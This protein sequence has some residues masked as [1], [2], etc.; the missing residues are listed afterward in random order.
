MKDVNWFRRPAAVSASFRSF[1]ASAR[2]AYPETA[3]ALPNASA[4]SAYR[5]ESIRLLPSSKA[6]LNS[7]WRRR[8]SLAV[9]N[10]RAVFP[11]SSYPGTSRASR[12]ASTAPAGSS[13]A[14]LVCAAATR[15]RCS[16]QWRY[17]SDAAGRGNRQRRKHGQHGQPPQPARRPGGRTGD[18]ESFPAAGTGRDPGMVS[19][20]GQCFAA[21]PASRYTPRAALIRFPERGRRGGRWREVQEFLF[22]RVPR[23]AGGV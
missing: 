13:S 23:A 8:A 9:S 12:K 3:N 10:N 16:R 2:S 1:R 18:S 19:V 7:V 11:W 6:S 5:P 15:E 17:H 20:H 4:A 14:S 22:F 21:G